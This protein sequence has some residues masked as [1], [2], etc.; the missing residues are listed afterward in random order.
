MTRVMF[1]LKTRTEALHIRAPHMR[2]VFGVTL[3]VCPPP[4]MHSPPPRVPEAH[5]WVAPTGTT[6]FA[7]LGNYRLQSPIARRRHVVD[8]KGGGELFDAMNGIFGGGL[9]LLAWNGASSASTRTPRF[10]GPS[11]GRGGEM[12][13]VGSDLGVYVVYRIDW[14]DIQST[15]GVGERESSPLDSNIFADSRTRQTGH[16]RRSRCQIH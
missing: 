3:T 16:T 5:E 11:G 13:V 1:T 15:A 4:P 10:L 9:S 7:I 2:W 14:K 12:G 8:L 6:P